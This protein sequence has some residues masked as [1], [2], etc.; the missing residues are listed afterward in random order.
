[1]YR[2]EKMLEHYAALLYTHFP[3]YI[4]KLKELGTVFL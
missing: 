3:F 4:N 2:T 1:M